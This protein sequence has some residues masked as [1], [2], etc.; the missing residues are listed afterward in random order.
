MRIDP[1]TRLAV[2]AGLRVGAAIGSLVG[3]DTALVVDCGLL[4][5]FGAVDSGSGKSEIDDYDRADDWTDD[6]D[7]VVHRRV[8]S[9]CIADRIGS[10]YKD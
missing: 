5:T 10:S 1:T 6:T 7:E 3:I 8:S 2:N 9:G 4:D